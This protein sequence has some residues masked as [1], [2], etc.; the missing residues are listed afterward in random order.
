M[1]LRSK[2]RDGARGGRSLF[3][4]AA[5]RFPDD[6]PSAGAYPPIT[7]GD[8]A[9]SDQEAQRCVDVGLIAEWARGSEF[10]GG[11]GDFIKQRVEFVARFHLDFCLMQRYPFH[12]DFC[13]MRPGKIARENYRHAI[14]LF[15]M[16]ASAVIGLVHL[17]RI[18]G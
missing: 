12:S 3:P 18:L 13:L 9:R 8:R 1:K 7:H 2:E 5:R 16:V 10:D 17:N 6:K 4:A 11:R 15:L 14:G